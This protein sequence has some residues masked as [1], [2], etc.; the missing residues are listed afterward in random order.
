MRRRIVLATLLVTAVA[1]TVLGVPLGVAG[2]RLVRNESARRLDREADAVGVALE[3]T[4]EGGQPISSA[5]LRALLR[6]GRHIEVE[7]RHGRTVR[8][9]APIV[10]RSLHASVTAADG[11]TVRVDASARE[12]DERV[13]DLWL[14][15]TALSI[16]A[17]GAGVVLALFLAAR[18]SRPLSELAAVSRRLG[19]GDFSARGG[20]QG[21]PETDAVA[22]ALNHSAQRIGEL[23]TREREFSANASHQLRTPLTAL[24]MHLEELVAAGS[25]LTPAQRDE[26]VAALAQADR[27][28]TTLNELLALARRGRVG[29]AVDVD[30]AALVRAHA[31]TWR[32]PIERAGRALRIVADGPAMAHVTPG[33]VGHALDVLVENAIRHGGGTV[34]VEVGRATG[35][36]TVR[37]NDEGPGVPPELGAAIFQRAVS[38]GPGTGVGLPLARTLVESDGGRLELVS[39]RPAVFELFL[40]GGH[41]QTHSSR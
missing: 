32:R 9:G 3:D 34:T 28:E 16:A 40:P 31:A 11:A 21:V 41:D 18:L 27:L 10:G 12:V 36:A 5:R 33:A 26:A 7:D 13:R 19:A 35:R 1:V 22:D 17:L 39:A 2:A 20:H 6:P 25:T 23:V 38:S 24:H 15:V 37:V 14:L 29:E 8:A 30:V 4:L